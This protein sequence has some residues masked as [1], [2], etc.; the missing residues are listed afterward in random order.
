MYLIGPG[1]ALFEQNKYA[2]EFRRYGFVI[3]WILFIVLLVYVTIMVYVQ[4]NKRFI[5]RL[6]PNSLDE[7][8]SQIDT[9]I[10]EVSS[11]CNEHEI[12]QFILLIEHQINMLKS[13]HDQSKTATWVIL[14]TISLMIG[15]HFGPSCLTACLLSLPILLPILFVS[16][17]KSIRFASWRRMYAFLNQHS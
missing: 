12:N 2:L 3:N 14:F 13:N 10:K 15:D 17:V 5:R 1:A 8:Y 7:A 6:G 11:K 9:T 16:Y 4:Y